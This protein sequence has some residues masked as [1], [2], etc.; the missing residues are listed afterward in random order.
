[1]YNKGYKK[2]IKNQ[3]KFVSWF[4][5]SNKFIINDVNFFNQLNK[6]FNKQKLG[7]KKIFLK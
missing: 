7:L 5:I 2:A 4:I 3:A 6:W 1:M